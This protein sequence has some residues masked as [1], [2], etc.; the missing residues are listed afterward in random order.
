MYIC[1]KGT[2]KETIYCA[3][4]NLAICYRDDDFYLGLVIS[5]KLIKTEK[6]KSPSLNNGYRNNLLKIIM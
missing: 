2:L 5:V 3:C 4:K 6:G 1:F